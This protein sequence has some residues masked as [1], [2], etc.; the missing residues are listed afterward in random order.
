M[1]AARC[2][3]YWRVSLGFS[4]GGRRENRLSWLGGGRTSFWGRARWRILEGWPSLWFGGGCDVEG[5]ERL[6]EE[7]YC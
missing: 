4:W 3:N 6:I 1:E 5:C 2:M 7:L